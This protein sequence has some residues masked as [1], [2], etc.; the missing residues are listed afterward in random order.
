MVEGTYSLLETLKEK[1]DYIVLI[2]NPKIRKGQNA[3]NEIN[4][5]FEIIHENYIGKEK[6]MYLKRIV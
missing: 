4:M 1:L 2:I 6:I 5:D 3:L